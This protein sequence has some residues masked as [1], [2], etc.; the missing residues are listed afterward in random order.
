[1]VEWNT[2]FTTRLIRLLCIRMC[3]L[4]ESCTINFFFT[5]E[6][7]SIAGVGAAFYLQRWRISRVVC[8]LLLPN[9]LIRH[10]HLFCRHK[11]NIIKTRIQRFISLELGLH[12]SFPIVFMLGDSPHSIICAN[13][14][15]NSTPTPALEATGS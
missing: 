1:M 6:V 15:M 5:H 10:Y 11:G 9:I 3:T 8:V 14:C 13:F 2:F 4:S 12:L 7:A